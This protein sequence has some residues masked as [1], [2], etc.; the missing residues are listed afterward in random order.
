[1]GWL[2][3]LVFAGLTFAGLWRSRLLNRT[4]LEI[5]TVAILVGLAGYAWQGSPNLPGVS[6]TTIST[7][8]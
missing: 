6:A 5:A 7:T 3:L 1:M 2:F 8:G 4:A